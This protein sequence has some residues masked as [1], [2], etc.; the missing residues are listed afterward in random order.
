ML[1]FSI[2]KGQKRGGSQAVREW[3]VT[4]EVAMGSP[5]KSFM[6]SASPAAE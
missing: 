5:V 2:V 1:S 4:L 3:T 6:G